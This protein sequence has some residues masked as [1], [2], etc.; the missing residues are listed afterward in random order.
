M[1]ILCGVDIVEIN[2]IRKI[3][4]SDTGDAFRQ[5]VFT[6]A[7]IEY[8][9]S[10]K[11]SRYQSYA[12]RFAA[13]EAVSKALGTG[14]GSG[15]S[16]K[17]IEVLNHESGRPYVVLKGQ[18]QKIL[19]KLNGKNISVSLSHSDSDSIAFAVIETC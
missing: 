4:D 16:L 19:E 5:K 14:I 1:G 15:I 18:A 12:A 8:C 9:E 10:R 6:T 3:I 17:D 13:K 7:E 11:V 2:R